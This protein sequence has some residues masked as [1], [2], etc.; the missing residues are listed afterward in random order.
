MFSYRNLKILIA[1]AFSF[2]TDF[3]YNNRCSSSG[4]CNSE[5]VHIRHEPRAHC[6]KR[7]FED[8]DRCWFVV[9]SHLM[10]QVTTLGSCSARA[11]L[12][13]S[14]CLAR[15]RLMLGSCSACA[16]LM[17][18]SWSACARLVLGSCSTWR[19]TPPEIKL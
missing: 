16:R 12:V 3:E 8:I 5:L 11:R 15:V 14:S 7:T 1:L 13:L 18:G 9:R 2:F 17:L 19:K 10:P 4:C 6:A